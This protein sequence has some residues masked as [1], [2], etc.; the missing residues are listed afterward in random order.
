MARYDALRKLER[1]RMLKEYA[2]THPELS[3]KEIG[4]AFGVSGSRAWRIINGRRKGDDK[5]SVNK[6]QKQR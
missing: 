4:Q 1:N 5:T 6:S 3:Y 2:K